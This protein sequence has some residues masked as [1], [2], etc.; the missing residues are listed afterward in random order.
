VRIRD[1]PATP[2]KVREALAKNSR[3]FN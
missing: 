2:E 3:I 1:L